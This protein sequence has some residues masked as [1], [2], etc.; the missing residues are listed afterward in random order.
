MPLFLHA[1]I[2]T[3]LAVASSKVGCLRGEGHQWGVCGGGETDEIADAIPTEASTRK[4]SS[5][6]RFFCFLFSLSLSLFSLS[7]FR[8]ERERERGE[9]AVCGKCEPD[10]WRGLFLQAGAAE[11]E[12][13]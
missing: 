5:R 9:R 12:R 6:R 2:R 8:L 1:V 7:P 11:I 13:H 3:G 10:L 4:N